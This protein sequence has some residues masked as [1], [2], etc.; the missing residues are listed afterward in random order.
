MILIQEQLLNFPSLSP[1]MSSSGLSM[2][3][4]KMTPSTPLVKRIN[5]RSTTSAAEGTA[6]LRDDA[7]LFH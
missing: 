1:A 2:K 6:L 5:C 7:F 3:V 4:Y